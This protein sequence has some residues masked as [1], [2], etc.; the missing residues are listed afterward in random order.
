MNDLSLNG[1]QT[2]DIVSALVWRVVGWG[3][4]IFVI[5]PGMSRR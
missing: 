3:L 5:S 4:D 2:S 1:G